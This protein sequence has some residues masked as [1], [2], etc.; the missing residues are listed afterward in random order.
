MI[1][2][3]VREWTESEAGVTA[4]FS[5]GTVG[6]LSRSSPDYAY[7]VDALTTSGKAPVVVK[8]G[9]KG[10]VVAASPAD[11]DLVKWM[12]EIPEGGWL[13]V[14]T[15]M[16]GTPKLLPQ[17]PEFSRI[18]SV[19]NTSI[20]EKRGIWLAIKLPEFIVVDAQLVDK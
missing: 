11:R 14:M 15:Q 17:T 13:L 5:D 6:L 3:T 7:S 19:V 9:G 18:R 8:W 20:A 12:V 1:L 2:L 10:V 4:K 16:N